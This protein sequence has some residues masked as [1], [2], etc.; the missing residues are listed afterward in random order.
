[1]ISRREVRRRKRAAA[2]RRVLKRVARELLRGRVDRLQRKWD[3]Y[4]LKKH[5]PLMWAQMQ[6]VQKHLPDMFGKLASVADL[7]RKA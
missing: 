5:S 1:M 4:L 7:I 2:R 3:D 6:A